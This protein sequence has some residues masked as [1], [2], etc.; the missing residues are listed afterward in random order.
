[1]MQ[2]KRKWI[3]FLPLLLIVI[4]TLIIFRHTPVNVYDG[5]ENNHLSKYWSTERME[6]T[7]F[8]IQSAVTRKGKSAIKITLHEGDMAE[9][10]TEKDKA[11]ERDELLESMQLYAV[12]DVKYEYKFSMFLPD[13]FPITSTRLII[14]QW[15]Q[16][17]AHCAC[18]N[19]SPVLAIRYV[20]GKLCIT[21]QTE[22]AAKRD[23]L[24]IQQD[25]IRNRWLDF[26]FQIKFSQ[27]KNGEVIAY[28]NDK[29]IVR[30]N[31][32][33]SYADNCYVLS[34]KNKYFFKMGLYRDKM[35]QPMCIFIDEYEKKELSESNN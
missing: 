20:S 17:C 3:F 7:S 14:A 6:A 18:S 29:E 4:V 10:Q 16:L 15:K 11:T 1:M 8:Q 12:E 34:T 2:H 13:S 32:I 28:L 9:A 27:Q 26:R 33:T 35:T 23:T 25:E 19:Y 21:L 30:Y 5:F 31:G 24:F 22:P